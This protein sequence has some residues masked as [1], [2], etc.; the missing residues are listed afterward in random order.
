MCVS[1]PYVK[2]E[3]TQ[4]GR[5]EVKKTTRMRKSSVHPVFKESFLF[6]I[7]P[8][9]EDLNYTA[10]TLTVYDHARLRTDDVIGQ[11]RLGYGATEDTE[12]EHWN[13]A[14]QYP[15]KDFQ[16]WHRLMEIEGEN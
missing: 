6:I 12:F 8:K 13:Q 11:V 5:P 10:V 15:A 7:S 3:V 9:I 16:R 2:V 14:L 1:D 4:P